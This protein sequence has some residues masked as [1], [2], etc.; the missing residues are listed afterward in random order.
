MKELLFLAHR[1]PFPPNKG[2][3]IRSYN[4]LKHLS[5]D[6]RIHLGAFIDD[7]TDWVHCDDV[8]ALCAET[9]F[10]GINPRRNKLRSL[11]GLLTRE[12]LTLPYYRHC[13]M[14]AWINNI[15]SKPTVERV[16]VF[17]AAMAQY[18]GKPAG[19]KLHKVIDFVDVDSEKW[20]AYGDRKFWPL[21]WLYR[22]EGKTLLN[23]ER[24][25][26]GHFDASI[27]VSANEA[28]LFQ[29]LAP[30]VAARVTYVNNGVDT[31]YFHP[32][33][34][35]PNPYVEDQRVLIFTGAMDY[36][37]NVDAVQ[38]FAR[39]VFPKV[40]AK[41]PRASF[42][43]VGARPTEAVRQLDRMEGVH[44]TG[45]VHDIRS[46]LAHACVAVAPMRIARGIQNKVLE[47]MAMGKPVIATSAAMEGIQLYPEFKAL[48]ADQPEELAKKTIDLL[49]E[50]DSAGLG[51][52][53]RECV[54]THYSWKENLR[55][56][57]KLLEFDG[58]NS[59]DYG[60]LADERQPVDKR[61]GS[62]Y[63]VC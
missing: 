44:V 8:R 1:I 41:M 34:D 56:F 14:Q 15:L 53:G 54:I 38:W 2:D 21:R 13:A 46:Y 33:Y 50:G 30:E 37:A 31:A 3:K 51:K 16:L 20:R 11:I 61:I 5:Q 62:E 6:Y 26:A 7:P 12:P 18:V 63:P 42:F 48:I 27:F 29:K 40:L 39:E 9:L 28:A 25:V 35:Y 4:L 55:R 43:I 22:R 19:R 58:M 17:S 57:E 52:W 23:Y 36:W 60:S 49:L 32:G 10:L 24:I 59:H 45:A 47:A